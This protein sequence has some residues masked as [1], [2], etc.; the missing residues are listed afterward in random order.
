M[1]GLP[2]DP[3][4]RLTPSLRVHAGGPRVGFVGALD[5]RRP[6]LRAFPIAPLLRLAASSPGLAAYAGGFHDPETLARFAYAAAAAIAVPTNLVFGIAASW[7]IAKFEFPGK[8]C[9]IA[10]RSAVFDLAG[11]GRP[12]YVLLLGSQGWFGPWLAARNIHI[13]FAV[14]GIVLATT[15][16]PSPSW[17]AS[18]C[19]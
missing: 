10:D 13:I 17:R 12:I 3:F 18:C 5:R 7:A 1:N 16:S 14:P 9:L 15:S 8:S 11:R 19:P 6:V 2:A 4:E